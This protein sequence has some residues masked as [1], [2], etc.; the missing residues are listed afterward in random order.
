M[1]SRPRGSERPIVEPV[2]QRASVS[3][4]VAIIPA[5][6]ASERFP[7]KV[8]AAETGRPLIQHVYESARRASGLS[9]L[10][11]ATDHDEIA[12]AV[13]AFGGE[14]VMTR[15]DHPN[16]TS[17]LAE[18]AAQLDLSPDTIV[19]NIQG[20]EPE[21][22]PDAIDAAVNA[23]R[24]SNCPM[25]TVA[26]PFAR[27]EDARDPNVVKVVLRADGRALYFSR[28]MIPHPRDLNAGSAAQPSTLKHIG[29]YAYRADF[30]QVY[31]RLA[32]TPLELTEKLEQLRALEHGH[33]IAVAI[34]PVHSRGIDTP[35]Q[36]AA[37]IARWRARR[38]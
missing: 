38:E 22:E 10:L 2:V 8:L 21:I 26:S 17:R 24:A 11:V 33:D 5:R 19:V 25:A 9:R 13:R 28:A 15:A 37:F 35:E 32:P 30:L 36:Y 7:R 3:Q 4:V 12:A 16:G 18:A 14:V 27:D 29:L 23:L 6:F 31:V 20:D 1:N 34:R